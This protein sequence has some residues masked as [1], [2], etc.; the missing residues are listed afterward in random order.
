MYPECPNFSAATTL[1][2]DF[3]GVIIESVHAKGLA[4]HRLYEPFG[5]II[6]DNVLSHHLK[7]GGVSRYDKIRHFHREFLGQA[8]TSQEIELW[9]QKYSRLVEK[10]VV[11]SPLVPGAKEFFEKWKNQ[12]RMF[13]ASATPTEE[14]HRILDRLNLSKYF[15]RTW[16]Y[17]TEKVAALKEVLGFTLQS[18]HQVIMVGDS[19]SD[20]EASQEAKV[21]FIG[22]RTPLVKFHASCVAVDDFFGLDRILETL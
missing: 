2:F 7:A 20:Y 19:I 12:K 3:D 15:E 9:A 6:A 8:L 17:P 1:V 4:F 18:A 21:L 11:D 14:L 13:V 16:G 10:L 22:R 5:N